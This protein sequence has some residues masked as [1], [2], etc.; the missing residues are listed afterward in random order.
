[1]KSLSGQLGSLD[2]KYVDYIVQEWTQLCYLFFKLKLA[3]NYVLTADQ[4][5]FPQL[6]I[7][8]NTD[9]HF[10]LMQSKA[11]QCLCNLF[12]GTSFDLVVG[13][14]GGTLEEANQTTEPTIR[15]NEFF[16]TI[17]RHLAKFL[18]I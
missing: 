13:K 1:M 3:C 12:Q 11:I 17:M 8:I 4:Q 18:F 7:Y 9:S 15:E 2:T 10:F 14:L 16:E 6:Q 5:T